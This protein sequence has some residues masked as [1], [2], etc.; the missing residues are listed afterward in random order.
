MNPIGRH[1]MTCMDV[2]DLTMEE[3]ATMMGMDETT[4]EKMVTGEENPSMDDILL[5]CDMVDIP[6]EELMG[7]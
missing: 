5:F 3:V 1:M 6:F 4:F 2:R 7:I